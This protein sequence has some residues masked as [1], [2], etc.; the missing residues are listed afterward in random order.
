M[1]RNAKADYIKEKL[2]HNKSDPKKFWH[3]IRE[4]IPN[5]S[6]SGKLIELKDENDKAIPGHMLAGYINNYFATVGQTLAEKFDRN[7]MEINTP[8]H[9]FVPL[10][11]DLVTLEQLNKEVNKIAVYKSSGFK[12]ISSKIWKIVFKALDVYILHMINTSIITNQFP[13]AWKHATIVPIPKVTNPIDV[14]ELRPIALLPIIGKLVERFVHGQTMEYLNRH[15]LLSPYQNGF[16]QA[17]STVDTIYKLISDIDINN[18]SGLDTLAV[19]V[20]FKKAFDTVDHSVMIGKAAALNLDIS[21]LNW[22]SVYLDN[23]VQSTLINNQRSDKQMVPCGVPQGSIMGPLLFLI[24]INDI[25][26]DIYNSQLL[27]YADDLVIYRS[28]DRGNVLGV[29]DINIFQKDLD[30]IHSWC[31]TNKLTINLKKNKYMYFSQH[32]I[33]QPQ[34]K[35]GDYMLQLTR[36]YTYLGVVLDPQL[37][38]KPY[39]NQVR[40]NASYK[41]KLLRKIRKLLT[42]KAAET[43]AKSMVI[44]TM[45][46]GN[47]FLTG[48]SADDLGDLDVIHNHALRCA[49]NIYNPRDLHVDLLLL[50]ANTL[51]LRKK[52]VLQLLCII[53]RNINNGVF[54]T[55]V[56]VRYTRIHQGPVI[57]LPKP[58]TKSIKKETFLLWV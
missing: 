16:R 45:D 28:V 3:S 42:V 5:N 57:K 46:Y 53:K 55:Q 2:E 26:K 17:H 37:S 40:R 4:I 33:R 21:V 10:T 47:M 34:L 9:G 51:T 38:V 8:H 49:F 36:T 50:R 20:D 43:I 27:L 24:Y 6:S 30:V 35:M 39:I 23:R 1:V 52:R 31:S 56:P 18:N 54:K 11:L 44:P 29:S 22:L 25:D 41:L 15:E 14:G 12:N 19:Y 58:E 32:N 13:Y 7:Q 48:C